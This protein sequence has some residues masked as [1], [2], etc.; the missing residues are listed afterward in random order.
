MNPILSFVEEYK[1]NEI[2]SVFEFTLT[3]YLIIF[4]V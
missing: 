4:H 1:W 3:D 2:W